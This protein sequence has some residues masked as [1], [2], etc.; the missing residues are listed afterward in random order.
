M[1]T[2]DDT[3]R[4]GLD[5]LAKVSPVSDPP[6]SVGQAHSQASILTV[7]SL[8]K[9]EKLIRLLTNKNLTLLTLIGT[10][11]PQTLAELSRLSGRPKASLTRTLARLS[12][13]G[14]LVLQ[15][16]KGRGKAPVLACHQ[17]R[18]HVNLLAE[19]DISS[20]HS[21]SHPSVSLSSLE[22]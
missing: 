20:S 4:A 12:N 21:S 6:S 7:H 5:M 17:I 9:L 8:P 3:K 1:D 16:S 11:R 15:K 10:K 19:G 14:L 22:K 18:F 13:L 2:L